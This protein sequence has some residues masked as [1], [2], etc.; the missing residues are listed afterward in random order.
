MVQMS[1]QRAVELNCRCASQRVPWR[2]CLP[3]ANLIGKEEGLADVMHLENDDAFALVKCGANEKLARGFDVHH[4]SLL[5]PPPAMRTAKGGASRMGGDSPPPDVLVIEI[6]SLSRAAAH[7]HLP[8]LMQLLDTHPRIRDQYIDVELKLLGVAGSNSVPNQA[9]FLSGCEAVFQGREHL[10]GRP[11]TMLAQSGGGHRLWCPFTTNASSPPAH[12]PW[13]FSIAKQLGYTTFFG[14][15]IC[16]AGK[17]SSLHFQTTFT[18]TSAF[19]FKTHSQSTHVTQPCATSQLSSGS[20]WAIDALIKDSGASHSIDHSLDAIYCRIAE[21]THRAS[22]PADV[23]APQIPPPGGTASPSGPLFQAEF[24]TCI[25]GQNRFAWP[26][27]QIEQLWQAHGDSPKFAFYSSSPL[28]AWL[29]QPMVSNSEIDIPTHKR[30]ALE[31]YDATLSDFLDPFLHRHP[32]TLILLRGD[33]GQHHG[34]EAVEFDVQVEHRMPWGR[35]LVPSRLVPNASRLRTNA[36]RLLSP[37]DL[38]ATLQAAMLRGTIGQRTQPVETLNITGS[39]APIDLLMTEVPALRT[40]RQARIPAF[41]CPCQHERLPSGDF[42]YG[43][44][45]VRL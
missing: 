28:H 26:L 30:A 25:G 17:P 22:W 15:E 24:G 6:D 19:T 10:D 2:P 7:R 45:G 41:L 44:W 33:H 35:L 16:S 34:P 39:R 8:K 3:N 18:V 1:R 27:K 4:R 29:Q 5:V 38:H 21:Q 32:N 43:P 37:F 11:Q 12:P 40:C 14:E 31:A 20:P 42:S 13:L 9:A 23:P 36:E